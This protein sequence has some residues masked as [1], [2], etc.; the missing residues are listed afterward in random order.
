[1][2]PNKFSYIGIALLQLICLSAS[3]AVT[4]NGVLV[5]GAGIQYK[6]VVFEPKLLG[7]LKAKGRE[8]FLVFSGVGCNE[9]DM[10]RSIYIHT[11]SDPPM[12]SGQHGNIYS[13]PGKYYEDDEKTL[14]K[15][16]RM[17]VG[18]C[19]PKEKEGVV[20]FQNAKL[21]TGKWKRST[22]IARIEG[23]QLLDKYVPNQSITLREVLVS[24]KKEI[25]TEVPGE[26]LSYVP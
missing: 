18:A 6:T 5:Y 24:V 17:F 26:Y 13:H 11:P 23:Q 10:N 1:M 20:W 3:A 7:L 4:N 9:C 16:I 21:K 8:P 2:S 14:Y 25:C 19:L 12:E 22:F 15:T